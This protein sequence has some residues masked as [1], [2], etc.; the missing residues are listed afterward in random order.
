MSIHRNSAEARRQAHANADRFDRPYMYG[1]DSSGNWHAERVSADRPVGGGWSGV[2]AWTVVHPGGLETRGGYGTRRSASNPMRLLHWQRAEHGQWTARTIADPAGAQPYPGR[3]WFVIQRVGAGGGGRRP[4]FR[5]K[6]RSASGGDSILADR[7]FETLKE[8]Q[9]FAETWEVPF[10]GRNDGYGYGFDDDD[11]DNPPQSI[12]PHHDPAWVM[13]RY[14]VSRAEAVRLIE[15]WIAEE[16]RRAG[17]DDP[18]RRWFPSAIALAS[19][20]NAEQYYVIA[21]EN[22][23][24]WDFPTLRGEFPGGFEV[25][26]IKTYGSQVAR[27]TYDLPATTRQFKFKTES[28][29]SRPLPL[30]A[31]INW[32]D[33]DTAFGLEVTKALR[34]RSG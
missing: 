26:R 34:E 24:G 19:N 3:N 22:D 32:R 14:G 18:P 9:C 31:V 29:W 15:Q 4:A 17:W 20:A 16:R 10:S 1:T 30:N 23:Y 6:Y 33:V 13:K 2:P 28:G 21:V 25:D 12:M 8:A 5:L 27:V 11:N 7:D